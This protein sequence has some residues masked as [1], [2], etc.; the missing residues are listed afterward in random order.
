VAVSRPGRTWEAYI[1]AVKG[2][3][4]HEEA[5]GVVANG[6]EIPFELAEVCFKDLAKTSVRRGEEWFIPPPTEEE[7][8]YMGEMGVDISLRK[9]NASELERNR[10]TQPS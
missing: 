9:R 10:E 3:D 1:G 6:S 4:Y 2:D 5:P 7:I 8:K